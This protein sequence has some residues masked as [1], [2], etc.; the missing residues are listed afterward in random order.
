MAVPLENL[1]VASILPLTLSCAPGGDPAIDALRLSLIGVASVHRSFLFSRS[2]VYSGS[3]KEYM[4]LA[5]TFRLKSKQT[6]VNACAT[7]RGVQS[8]A[9]PGASLAI[10]L[11]DV[12]VPTA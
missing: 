9:A 1:M 5:C 2:Q 3:A 7:P 8:D 11:M 6:L 4:V 12:S 10:S